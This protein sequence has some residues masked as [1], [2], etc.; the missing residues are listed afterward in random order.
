MPERRGSGRRKWS[1]FGSRVDHLPAHR[2][3]AS[4]PGNR[5]DSRDREPR[6]PDHRS[7]WD[8]RRVRGHRRDAA[9]IPLAVDCISW[10][11]LLAPPQLSGPE[12]A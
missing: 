4:I 11:R 1:S 2:N 7:I 5:M 9:R 8:N 10:P 3:F 6:H 12:P